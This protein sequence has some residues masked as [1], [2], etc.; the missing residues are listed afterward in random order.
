MH[1]EKIV[2]ARFSHQISDIVNHFI[3]GKIFHVCISVLLHIV[4]VFINFERSSMH[5]ES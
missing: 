1:V 4:S 3:Y 2:E 5:L